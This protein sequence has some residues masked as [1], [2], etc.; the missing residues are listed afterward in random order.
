MNDIANLYSGLFL[1]ALGIFIFLVG[2]KMGEVYS[3]KIKKNK[4]I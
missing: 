1:I 2:V 4:K 3:K